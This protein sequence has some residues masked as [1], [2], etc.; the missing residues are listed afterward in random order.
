MSPQKPDPGSL[1]CRMSV[2]FNRILVWP[3]RNC[4]L[5]YNNASLAD[6]VWA[7]VCVAGGKEGFPH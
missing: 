3:P 1:L 7:L 5:E 6:C 2:A 4:V